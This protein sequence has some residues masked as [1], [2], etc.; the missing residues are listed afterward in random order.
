MCH[1]FDKYVR[2]E[3]Q[4]MKPLISEPSTASALMNYC[5]HDAV[6][7]LCQWL[8]YTMSIVRSTVSLTIFSGWAGHRW[9][10]SFLYTDKGRTDYKVSIPIYPL[11][12]LV[13][14]HTCTWVFADGY[15]IFWDTLAFYLEFT[16]WILWFRRN[17]ES[18]LIA[19][20][21]PLKTIS[22]GFEQNDEARKCNYNHSVLIHPLIDIAWMYK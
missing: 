18:Q 19:F 2:L 11:I 10:Y 16:L 21:T 22:G 8:K 14:E 1:Y 4:K 7:A 6:H 12:S 3:I 15:L 5:G 13:Q 20:K 9:S 17:R